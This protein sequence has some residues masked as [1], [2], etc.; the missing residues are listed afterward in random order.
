VKLAKANGARVMLP[1]AIRRVTMTHVFRRLPDANPRVS[2]I[3]ADI[4]SITVL[5]LAGII[6]VAQFAYY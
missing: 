6:S 1:A 2:E 4:L 3:A 5:V